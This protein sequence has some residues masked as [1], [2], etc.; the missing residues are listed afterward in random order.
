MTLTG[1]GVSANVI[2][3]GA[4]QFELEAFVVGSVDYTLTAYLAG[5]ETTTLARVRTVPGETT[6][7]KDV[8]LR[9]GC[10]EHGLVVQRS[11]Q[12]EAREAVLVAHI[13]VESV[14]TAQEWRGEYGCVIAHEVTAWVEADAAQ[15]APRQIR[16][17]S[18]KGV[19]IDRGDE[20]VA[21][22]SWEPVVRRHMPWTVRAQVVNGIVTLDDQSVSEGLARQ[23]GVDELLRRLR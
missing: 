21:A 19:K 18:G 14:A 20:Y 11:L 7:L 5:F 16:F 10:V 15:G 12:A 3:D 13:R 22:F 4:G 2:T 17:L 6:S 9:L 1:N 23:M 8:V